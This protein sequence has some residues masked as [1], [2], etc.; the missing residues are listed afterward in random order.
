MSASDQ[1][2]AMRDKLRGLSSAGAEV[3]K[4]AA[5][6]VGRELKATASAGT[7]PDG[8]RWAPKKDGSP[9]LVNA[10]AAVEVRA[11]GPVV[12]ARLVGTSTG[13][14]T[15]QAIQQHRRNIL[16]DKSTIP[17]AIAKALTKAGDHYARRALGGG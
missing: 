8:A 3:A 14:Q 5:P 4:L 12:Q 7:T 16:P 10:A 13:S 1:I 9:A 6:L 2:A 15:A 17:A 11:I